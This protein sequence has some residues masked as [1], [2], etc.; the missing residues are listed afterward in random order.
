MRVITISGMA[1]GGKDTMGAALVKEFAKQGVKACVF[2]YADMLKTVARVCYGWDGAKD[3]KGRQLLQNLGTEGFR[4]IDPDIWVEAIIPI[5]K[6]LSKDFNVVV[7]PDV[8]FINEAIKLRDSMYVD[9]VFSIK[10]ERDGYDNGL[11]EEQKKH[12][13]ENGMKGFRFDLIVKNTGTLEEFQEKA[14]RVVDL[15][16]LSQKKETPVI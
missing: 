7:L 15:Y 14:S 11:T 8:R 9:G 5:L 3:E 13:S 4:A 6:G 12:P 1:R 2:H 16:N 10:I